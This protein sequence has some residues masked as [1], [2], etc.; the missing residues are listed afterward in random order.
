M[1]DLSHVRAV[2]FDLDDT[3]CAYWDA[4]KAA[5]RESFETHLPDLA[6]EDS[7]RAWAIAFREFCPKLRE[8]GLLDAYK[9]SGEVTRTELMRRT[10]KVLQ[11][12]DEALAQAL[13]HSYMTL[14]DRNLALFPDAIDVL[15]TLK[16]HYPL[17][18]I[19]NGPADI[20]RQEIATLR[21]ESYFPHIYIEGELPVGKPDPSVFQAAQ[22]AV[23]CQPHEVLMV[24]NSY[25][26]DIAAAI[27][28]GW[29]TAWI[30]RPSDVPPSV[31]A[32]QAKPEERP[33]GGPIPDLTIGSL[34]ELLPKLKPS[35]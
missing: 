29:R 28:A 33:E 26:H 11:R 25:H 6:A 2:Y 18:L 30:R 7:V 16:P 17:G 10:L 5:L 23:D 24:G 15:N 3:L 9:R 34:S 32:A 8:L 1:T 4:S 21:L 22:E 31:E 35:I 27:K 19:T 20:Q 14:R 13:S 12:E